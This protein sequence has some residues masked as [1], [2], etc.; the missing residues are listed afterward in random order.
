ML[1][2]GHKNT[3]QAEAD[4]MSHKCEVVKRNNGKVKR[5]LEWIRKTGN[6]DDTDK[7]VAKEFLC[8]IYYMDVRSF[9]I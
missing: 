4:S 7:L 2:S 5:L 3:V 6:W 1:T 9:V 8:P